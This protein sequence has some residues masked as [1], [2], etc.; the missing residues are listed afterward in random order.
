MNVSRVDVGS[1]KGSMGTNFV[2]TE[3]SCLFCQEQARERTSSE[4]GRIIYED[5]LFV[6]S[7]RLDESELSYLGLILIRTKRH[8]NDLGELSDAE[9]EGLGRLIQRVGKA[10]KVTTGAAW[11]YCYSF[12]EGVRH[13]HVFVTARYPNVPKE[14]V[15]LDIAK[16]P[17]APMGREKE[18]S[19]LSSRIRTMLREE[20]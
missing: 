14:Y 5:E 13:V 1:D 20:N 15:R 17:A 19:E 11:T 4:E 3:L 7:H 2:S 6:A 18:V 16:W 10:L 9:A 8:V 12:L